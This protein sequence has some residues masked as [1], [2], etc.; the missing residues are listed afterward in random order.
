MARPKTLSKYELSIL[1]GNTAIV[2]SYRSSEY[3]LKEIGKYFGLHYSSVSDI[4][5]NHKPDPI[6]LCCAISL[7]P[8]L[9]CCQNQD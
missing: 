6:S 3:T 4:I 1:N 8:A 5:K 7:L 9:W 2:K